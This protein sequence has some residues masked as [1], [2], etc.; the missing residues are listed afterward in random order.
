[1]SIYIYMKGSCQQHPW[2]PGRPVC[3]HQS[4]SADCHLHRT[5]TGGAEDR[6]LR[7]GVS[8]HGIYALPMGNMIF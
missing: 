7:D 3:Q 6:S 5:E 4:C 2:V 1:M 8:E